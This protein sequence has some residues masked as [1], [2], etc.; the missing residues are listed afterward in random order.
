MSLLISYML[1]GLIQAL[2]MFIDYRH[3]LRGLTPGTVLLAFLFYVAAWP[4][5]I[6]VDVKNAKENPNDH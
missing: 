2:G 1:I 4:Y 5:Y 3:A 6:A